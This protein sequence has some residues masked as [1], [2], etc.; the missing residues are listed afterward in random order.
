MTC[1]PTQTAA[2]LP[3]RHAQAEVWPAP[4]TWPGSNEI[5]VRNR[6]VAIT[7][8][9]RLIPLIGNLIC[10]WIKSPFVLGADLAGEVGSAVTRFRVADRVLGHAAGIDKK[11]SSAAKGAF[12]RDEG[13]ESISVVSTSVSVDSY[14]PRPGLKLQWPPL[15]LRVLA[16]N[17]SLAARSRHRRRIRIVFGSPLMDNEVSRV[18]DQNVLSLA[19]AGGR[20]VAPEPQIVSYG[21]ESVQVGLDA[22]R[23]SVSACKVVVS[24]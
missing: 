9:D 16:P 2:W 13:R 17:V 8:F 20:H 14:T 5:V 7:P 6:A 10:P 22:Q 1:T 4:P 19:L 12:Q 18:V 21:L 15:R 3:A 11:R 23:G 24:L